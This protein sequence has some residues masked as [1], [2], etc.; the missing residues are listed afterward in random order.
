MRLHRL[1]VSGPIDP[2]YIPMTSCRTPLMPATYL[3]KYQ[4]LS[5]IML[6]C[7]VAASV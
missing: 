5:E 1:E 4:V 3:Q 2:R 6:H 7:P